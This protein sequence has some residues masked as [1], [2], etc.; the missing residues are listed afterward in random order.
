MADTV[1]KSHASEER[2]PVP[3]FIPPQSLGGSRSSTGLVMRACLQAAAH[4]PKD[5][6]ER[7]GTVGE[8]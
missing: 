7:R 2:P 8:A 1:R 5:R 6:P 3:T 4:L